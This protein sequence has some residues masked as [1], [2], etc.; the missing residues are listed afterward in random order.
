MNVITVF[1]GLLS[2]F[3]LF[4]SSIKIFGWQ[5]F[6]FEAQLAMFI[7]YGL[8]RQIMALVGVVELFGAIAIWFQGSWVGTLGALAI[9]GA[10][11]GAIGCHLIWDTWKEAVPAMVTGTLSAIVAW[12]GRETVLSVVGIS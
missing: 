12:S 3:F 5:K 8:N 4:A 2:V 6:I 1:V 9:L 10:S 11:I 7:K